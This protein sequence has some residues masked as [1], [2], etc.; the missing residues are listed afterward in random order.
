MKGLKF[1]ALSGVVAHFSV[2]G[3]IASADLAPNNSRCF[4]SQVGLNLYVE[5]GRICE[6][7]SDWTTQAYC[8]KS[9]K[10]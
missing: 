4:D 3:T 9:S 5:P 10:L 8:S 6:F 1:M 2:C 7:N